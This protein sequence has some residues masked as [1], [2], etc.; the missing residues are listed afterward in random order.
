MF[1]RLSLFPGLWTASKKFLSR[2][3]GETDTCTYR[4]SGEKGVFSHDLP[5][6]HGH[7]LDLGM[8]DALPSDDF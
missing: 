3:V 6:L 1:V 8:G 4:A 5:S 2:K 7:A